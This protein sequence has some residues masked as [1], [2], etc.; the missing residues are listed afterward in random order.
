MRPDIKN[1][2]QNL[3]TTH[4]PIPLKNFLNPTPAFPVFLLF[5]S[6]PSLPFP[7][8]SVLFMYPHPSLPPKGKELNNRLLNKNNALV[9]PLWRNRKGG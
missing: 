6:N 4:L 1:Q 5:I 9:I 8:L 7:L 3:L 2:F